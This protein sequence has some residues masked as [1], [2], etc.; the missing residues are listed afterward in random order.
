MWWRLPL[1]LPVYRAMEMSAGGILSTSR[2]PSFSSRTFLFK[3]NTPQRRTLFLAQ[4]DSTPQALLAVPIS[5]N[6][7][8]QPVVVKQA[9]IFL[10]RPFSP[11]VQPRAPGRHHLS[12]PCNRGISAVE[13]P[14]HVVGLRA[15]KMIQN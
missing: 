5:I 2:C 7:L 3:I 15:L 4:C 6:A 10:Y 8:A 1:P 12:L 13:L 9:W 11:I 14:G